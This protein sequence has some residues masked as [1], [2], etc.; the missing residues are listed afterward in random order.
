MSVDTQLFDQQDVA[1]ILALITA[2]VPH[3]PERFFDEYIGR[4]YSPEL[5]MEAWRKIEAHF[6]KGTK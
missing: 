6:R 2:G 3:P 5:N 4:R 1:A